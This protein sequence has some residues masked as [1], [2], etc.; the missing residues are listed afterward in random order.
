MND[1]ISRQSE[2]ILA[3]Y[4]ETPESLIAKSQEN[5]IEKGG[6]GSKGGKII[7]HTKSGKPIY[8]TSSFQ[9][10]KKAGFSAQDHRDA[11]N[12]HNHVRRNRDYLFDASTDADY[13]SLRDKL[14]D[15]GQENVVSKH[16]NAKTKSGKRIGMAFQVGQI[17]DIK[18]WSPQDH[19]DAAEH[20]AKY[21]ER[22]KDLKNQARSGKFDSPQSEDEFHKIANSHNMT[23]STIKA[24]QRFH[25]KEAEKKKED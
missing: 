10:N 24:A 22:W 14:Q 2:K 3:C 18:D 23:N 1:F 12:I 25:E 8:K 7:G 11:A 15:E 16:A 5:D 6:E 4:G 20:H 9:D 13:R 21:L 19:K 17:E